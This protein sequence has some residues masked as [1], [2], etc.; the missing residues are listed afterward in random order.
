[1]LKL[2]EVLLYMLAIVAVVA[3]TSAGIDK[4]VDWLFGG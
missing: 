2:M 3:L 1:M 4:L